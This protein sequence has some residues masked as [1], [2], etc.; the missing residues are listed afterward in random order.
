MKIKTWH[1][2]VYLLEKF[3]LYI[4]LVTLLL[5]FIF[6]LSNTNTQTYYSKNLKSIN[7]TLYELELEYLLCSI[8][9]VI[10]PLTIYFDLPLYLSFH[11][12]YY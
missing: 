2:Q 7:R 5:T 6:S 9:G 12:Y 4:S 10:I 1:Y 3:V 11:Y 8:V